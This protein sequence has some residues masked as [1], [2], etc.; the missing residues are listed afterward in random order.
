MSTAV[1]TATDDESP[2]LCVSGITAEDA[3]AVMEETPGMTST[4]TPP[5]SLRKAISSQPPRANTMGSPP[6]SLHTI[7]PLSA[8]AS[9]ISFIRACSSPLPPGPASFPTGMACAEA[10]ANLS[11][12]GSTSLSY[13]ITSHSLRLQRPSG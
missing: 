13:R 11:T 9:I 1:I 10:P 8:C 6:L 7:F 12:A 4:S 2:P 3:Q 5:C